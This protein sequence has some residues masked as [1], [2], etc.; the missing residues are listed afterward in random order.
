MSTLSSRFASLL[1]PSAKTGCASRASWSR[2]LAARATAFRIRF[3]AFG[4]TANA[5]SPALAGDMGRAAFLMV[6]LLLLSGCGITA[7]RSNEGYADLDS[8]GMFDTDRVIS[9]S[10][11][12]T[13]LHFAARYIDDDPETRDLLRSL[14]GVRVR[15]YEVDGDAQKVAGRMENMSA[16]LQQDGWEPV[17]MVR[18]QDEQAH[19]LLRT[20]DGEIRGMIVLVL[21]GDSEA[22]IVNLMGEIRPEQFGNVMVALDVDAGGVEVE[23]DAG[24]ASLGS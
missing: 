23:T 18:K 7:P 19:M 12:P 1:L 14:D 2:S 10:I 21:D 17:M 8:L 15:I 22:V 11:G 5:P 24:N 3:F 6:V 16:N 13:L 9:L 4:K 20:V